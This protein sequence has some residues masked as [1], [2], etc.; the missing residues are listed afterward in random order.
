MATNEYKVESLFIERLGTIGYKYIE[1][2]NYTEVMLNFK[3]QLE[4][5]NKEE[6]IKGKG[7]QELSVAEFDRLRTQIENKTVYESAK[8]LRDKQVL[9]LDNGKR[10]YI[11]FLS[12]DIDRNIYQVTH[13]VTMDKDHLSEVVYKNRY[14][15]TVLIN[16]LPLVQI[17]LK[18]PGV[19]INEAINQI[20]RYRR[21][22]FRGLFHFIQ[23][24]VVSN[25]IQTKY[26][27]NENESNADGTYKALLKSLAFFWTDEENERIN[28]LD[29][30]TDNFFTKYNITALLTDYTVLQDML[31]NIIVMRPYQIYA[32]KAVMRRV[33]E[34]NKNGYVWHTTGS[35]KTLTSFKCASLLRDNGR[36]DKVF[37]LVDRKDLDDQ[38]VEEYNSFEEDCVDN[39]D[40]TAELIKR[41]KN[42]GEKML[43]TTIQKLA[44]ALRIAGEK[45]DEKKY[46]TKSSYENALK[47]HVEYKKIFE[48]F[49]SRKCVFVIDECHRSQFGKM[50][51]DI[52]RNFQNANFIG[53]TGTPIFEEN[54]GATGQTTA[55]IFNAGKMKS[56][57]HKYLIKE[58]IADGNVLKFSVEYQNTFNVITTNAADM[59]VRRIVHEQSNNPNF[60][61]EEYCKRNNIDISSIYNDQQRIELVT[62]NILEHY[63]KHT[64]IGTDTYT[65]LFAIQSVPLLQKYYT[66]FKKLNNK[67]L[68]IAAIFTYAANEDMDEGAD[69]PQSREFLE[70]CIKDYNELF[71]TDKEKL[72]FGLDTFDAYR[73][74]IAKRL[75]QKEVP[76]IDILLVVD[77]FLTGFDSKPL[78]TLYLDKPLFW[79][80][81]VQAYSRTN[82]IY[83]E[84]KQYGQIITF[85][86][87]K[88]EQDKAL[89]LFSGDGNPNAYLL[90]N[91]EYYVTEYADRVSIMRNVAPSYDI[92]G[93]LQSEDDQRKFIVSFRLVAQTL[94]TL[95]TFSKFDWNDL[96]NVL[97]EDEFLGYKSWY[98]YYYDLAK[99]ERENNVKTTLVDIDFNIELI[100]TDKINVVYILN[101]LKDVIKKDENEKKR[102]I[103]LILR[104]IERSDNEHLRAKQDML[105]RFVTE[106]FFNLSPDEDIVKAYEE[107]EIQQQNMDIEIFAEETG[108]D[109]E[110]IKFF[111]SEYQFKHVISLEDIRKRLV[112]K[113]YKLLQTIKLSSEIVDFIKEQYEKFR[114]EGE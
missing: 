56:C 13:Q 12:K 80:S 19:E 69:T 49:Q 92:A 5:F 82:R 84:T 86:N 74:D 55:D 107:F 30:F 88:E 51:G 6:I 93:R 25:S 22:S 20:N 53:F 47:R 4:E 90:E 54:K 97:D 45:P 76:Q 105:K 40:S 50:H 81:L 87:I 48:T 109:V 114:A 8:I 31:K 11:E 61:L 94:S 66:A 35:G 96:I 75:K 106:K 77:M 78:N 72:S 101:L 42:C 1:L 36:I 67:G 10:I 23:C 27:A 65:S 104:E 2:K 58:A 17:E 52:R 32:T 9:E 102:S 95:K 91:Y 3:V 111:M 59:T 63:E 108:L 33:L 79:H 43:V 34:E 99:K 38:T 16:G 14:D 60:N 41:L 26:F 15:V 113:G 18:R 7:T 98:L 68:K 24:F 89:K 57:L 85:R 21:Y 37:F 71:S 46:K 73:K 39:T 103:D 70:A 112:Q 44:A 29:G 83:K 100:R 64:K 28:K 110:T 62:N